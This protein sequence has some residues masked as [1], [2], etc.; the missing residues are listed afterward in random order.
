MELAIGNWKPGFGDWELVPESCLEMFRLVC[1]CEVI[2]TIPA[3]PE[4]DVRDSSSRLRR[5][6]VMTW[7]EQNCGT[8]LQSRY[9]RSELGF[10][11]RAYPGNL[12][13]CKCGHDL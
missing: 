3:V 6:F 10:I 11:E 8:T 12:E 13:S 1:R 5:G 2:P 9:E 7:P 4:D